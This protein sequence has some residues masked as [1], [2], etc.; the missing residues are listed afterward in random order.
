MPP[1][2]L[3]RNPMR[4]AYRD[5]ETFADVF[6]K[7]TR[8]T[9]VPDRL[10]ISLREFCFPMAYSYWS[11][12]V[13]GLIGRVFFGRSP[14]KIGGAIVIPVS[15]PMSGLVESR[16]L[17]PMKYCAYED[18]ESLAPSRTQIEHLVFAAL[19]DRFQYSA[20]SEASSA[21]DRYI[22]P[23]YRPHAPEAGRFVSRM[24][25]YGA[26]LFNLC[27]RFLS[28]IA[29]PKRCGQG[30]TEGANQPSFP[31]YN[32]RAACSMGITL[33]AARV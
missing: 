16:W 2:L 24:A 9:H 26:P 23:I 3:S 30:M 25:G 6:E 19:N 10:D 20:T 11:S 5:T 1:T 8:G 33:L 13:A 12:A 31:I 17:R 7:R 15:V 32:R 4:V 22:P 14:T 28:H 21:I 27:Y 18:V 29:P